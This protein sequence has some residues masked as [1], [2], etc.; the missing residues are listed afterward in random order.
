MKEEPEQEFVADIPSLRFS[1]Q[2]I[3]EAIDTHKKK[4]VGGGDFCPY[5]HDNMLQHDK[6]LSHVISLT[7]MKTE[8]HYSLQ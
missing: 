2:T 5:V 7:P 4:G 3:K 1:S 8:I 6:E